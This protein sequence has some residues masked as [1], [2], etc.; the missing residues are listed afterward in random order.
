MSA[1][2]ALSSNLKPQLANWSKLFEA[3]TQAVTATDKAEKGWHQALYS[4][5]NE[6]Y[7][8]RK[9]LAPNADTENIQVFVESRDMKWGAIQKRN[10]FIPLVKIAFPNA[11]DTQTSKYGSVLNFAW[12]QDIAG[13]FKDWINEIDKGLE[14]RYQEA[15]SASTSVNSTGRSDAKSELLK[16]AVD[17]L[18]KHALSDAVSLK[19]PVGISNGFATILVRVLGDQEVQIVKV[20]EKDQDKIN[21]ILQRFGNKA[22]AARKTLEKRKLFRLFRAIELVHR[23]ASKPTGDNLRY[24]IIDSLA[25]GRKSV[26]KVK[27]VASMRTFAGAEARIVGHSMPLPAGSSF[28]ID[29]NDIDMFVESFLSEDWSFSGDEKT[30]F[31]LVCE[32]EEKATILLQPVSSIA[33]KELYVSVIPTKINLAAQFTAAT[34]RT[35][36]DWLEQTRALLSAD[37]RS[38]ERKGFGS[39]L[40][41]KVEDKT[42]VGK[43]T[44]NARTDVPLFAVPDDFELKSERYIRVKDLENLSS[45]ASDYDFTLEGG[46]G[47]GDGDAP[48]SFLT[49]KQNL[50][51]DEVSFCIPLVV[52]KNGDYLSIGED[53]YVPS[54]K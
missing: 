11:S 49:L 5:L 42:L 44:K 27:A 7:E 36:I 20:L 35:V 3:V 38:P 8:F 2:P 15:L 24:I 50:K 41:L 47:D 37:D 52:S 48:F 6:L 31:S 43:P 51:T 33:E 34:G 19:E 29:T 32:N 22:K 12:Q 13:T 28:A 54:S 26:L 39:I 18:T 1:A 40:H 17:N 21:P 23:I 30:G 10:P 4:A 46:F 53:R 45:V 14:K 16:D 25:D 9:K